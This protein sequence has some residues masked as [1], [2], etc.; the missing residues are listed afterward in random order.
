MTWL[1]HVRRGV[2]APLLGVLVIGVGAMTA[3]YADATASKIVTSAGTRPEFASTQG[4][5]VLDV[6]AY[7]RVADL[8]WELGADGNVFL[9]AL[10]DLRDQLAACL[11]GATASALPVHDPVQ[12]HPRQ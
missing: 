3:G 9:N 12:K 1:K 6:Y 10:D 2:R 7:L 8:A 11:G 4:S 5:C